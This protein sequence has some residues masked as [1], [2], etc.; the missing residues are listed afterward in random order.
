MYSILHLSLVQRLISEVSNHRL[1]AIGRVFHY[2]L[3][4]LPYRSLFCFLGKGFFLHGHDTRA[5]Q[6]HQDTRLIVAYHEAMSHTLV[7]VR[8]L[9]LV[10]QCVAR[11]W[12]IQTLV[13][14]IA[15]D[16]VDHSASVLTPVV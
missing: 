6:V 3:G 4:L 1:Q 15:P 14:L 7:L 8:F 10:C 2:A 9:H 13:Y 16:S 12:H 11:I 5:V